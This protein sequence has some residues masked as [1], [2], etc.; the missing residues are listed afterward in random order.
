[1]PAKH[2]SMVDSETS[3]DNS[4]RYRVA[5]TEYL[6]SSPVGELLVKGGDYIGLNTGVVLF[7]LTR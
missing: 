3:F 4:Y 6:E 1:M 7:N 5:A 2:I